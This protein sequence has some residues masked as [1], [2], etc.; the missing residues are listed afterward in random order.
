MV[1]CLLSR[2]DLGPGPGIGVPQ[3]AVA[4][5][6]QARLECLCGISRGPGCCTLLRCTL[7]LA[8]RIMIL[9][10]GAKPRSTA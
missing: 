2:P 9:T 5:G 6:E 1:F 7:G 8:V 3:A 4:R 10:T